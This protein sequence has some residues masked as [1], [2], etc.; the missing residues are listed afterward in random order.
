M[1]G[2]RYWTPVAKWDGFSRLRKNKKT[3]NKKERA[4]KN[5]PATAAAVTANTAA[6]ARRTP[7]RLNG[8]LEHCD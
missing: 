3:K 1:L 7:V 6:N 4:R 8:F 5:A 2:T